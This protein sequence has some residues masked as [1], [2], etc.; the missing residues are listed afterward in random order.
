M[1]NH[2][3]KHRAP[4]EDALH[5]FDLAAQES[6][7]LLLRELRF[8]FA[9]NQNPFPIA[10]ALAEDID[11]ILV[12]LVVL[13]KVTGQ[14]RQHPNAVVPLQKRGQRF[15]G[16][17]LEEIAKIHRHSPQLTRDVVCTPCEPL[18]RLHQIFY[19]PFQPFDCPR[20]FS[21]LLAVL[22]HNRPQLSDCPRVFS[23][24][25]AVLFHD[26][27]QLSDCPRVFGDLLAVAFGGGAQFGNRAGILGD[28]LAV[29]FG[30]GAQRGN[31]RAVLLGHL[32]QPRNLLAVLLGHLH[33]PRQPLVNAVVVCAEFP[34]QCL[35]LSG[36][37]CLHHLSKQGRHFSSH[38][39]RL[40]LGQDSTK[41]VQQTGPR[42]HKPIIPTQVSYLRMS[43]VLLT[44]Q[45]VNWNAREPLRAALRSILAHPPRFP[46][47]IVVL[48]NASSDGS[49]QMLE[50]EFPEVRL[51][52][53]EQN[54]GF[55]RGHNLAA[56]AAQGK[57]LFILNPDTETLPPALE[58][59]VNYAE[60]HPEVAI[61]GPK[62]LNPDG[63]LQYSCRRFPNPTAAL[64][65]NTP[66]G[67]LFPNNPYTREYL[68]TDWDHNSVR[69]VD[70][71]SGA[72]LLIRR[73]VYEQLGGFDERF[74]MYCEDTDLCYRAWQAGYTVV[75]YPEP[76]IVHAIGRSTDLV[77][78]KMI[79]T[80][81][82]S[83]YL[84]YKKHY[85]RKTFLLLRPLVPVALALRASLFLL[86]N[87]SDALRRR[88]GRR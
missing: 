27:P 60:Q 34:N 67:K 12:A 5:G 8:A 68:M 80:F 62:I 78:N 24:L 84:F 17:V 48:D 69:E 59:L 85:A 20:I 86:K 14:R 41:Q 81:H 4:T 50:K 54:L 77:A 74:F 23:D 31:L 9:D 7:N 10:F 1:P 33:Q 44:V 82:R 36:D 47:E 3:R 71:V 83:M 26:C 19:N 15:V 51:L 32:H 46:Y 28:L 39:L 76:K 61:I 55:S 49:V 64:F 53:S 88:V 16:V 37:L 6:I 40:L 30:G 43:E 66:L 42:F 13:N 72:A 56:R 45:I 87:Y 2:H 29:A 57:Y 63:S 21:D 25:L 70:W 52:V 18:F 38:P 58:L 65:R 35:Q 75:Y 22:F 73:A 11:L 79:I